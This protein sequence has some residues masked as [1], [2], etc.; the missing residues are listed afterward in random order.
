[1]VSL[2]WTH[3]GI[4]YEASTW[5]L[6][7]RDEFGRAFEAANGSI[8]VEVGVVTDDASGATRL[9]SEDPAAAAAA[10]DPW[11]LRVL[12]ALEASTS[13]VTYLAIP[14]S[15]QRELFATIH[16]HRPE[17]AEREGCQTLMEAE[18]PRWPSMSPQ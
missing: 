17:R 6:G 12:N 15:R 3:V 13:L 18:E 4:V 1:M 7:A 11:P 9:V 5:G 14:P 10:S 2:G 16:T 8:L